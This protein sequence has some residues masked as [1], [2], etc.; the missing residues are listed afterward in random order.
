MGERC[1]EVA[2]DDR[3]TVH[4]G[5]KTSKSEKLDT[6]RQQSNKWGISREEPCGVESDHPPGQVHTE[7]AGFL[8]LKRT[9]DR[10]FECTECDYRP[11]KKV[12]LSRHTRKHTGEKPYKC[13]ICDY[14]AAKKDHLE[15]HMEK[16]TSEKRFMCVECGYRTGVKPYTCDY[17]DYSAARKF[18]LDRHMAK[19]TDEKPFMCGK[20]GYRAADLSYLTP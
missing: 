2:M 15:S 8:A 18:H 6:E 16:H 11:A 17:C 3:S 14:S 13:D 4:H 12:K 10:R 1:S 20:C 9:V 7:Q 19:H 5:D